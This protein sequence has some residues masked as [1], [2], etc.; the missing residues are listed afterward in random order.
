[1]DGLLDAW[2]AL[3]FPH[4]WITDWHKTMAGVQHLSHARCLERVHCAVCLLC[5]SRRAIGEK[6][7]TKTRPA[8]DRRLCL[9]PTL[10]FETGLSCFCRY[11]TRPRGPNARNVGVLHGPAAVDAPSRDTAFF[12]G[13]GSQQGSHL[14]SVASPSGLRVGDTSAAGCGVDRARKQTRINH[15]FLQS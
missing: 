2:P 7:R 3:G 11:P 1:M 14:C 10:S 6:K 8:R 5:P 9:P 13:H 4:Q 15:G 12:P